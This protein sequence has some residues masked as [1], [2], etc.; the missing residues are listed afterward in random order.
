MV[1]EHD[2]SS[3][4]EALGNDR[5]ADFESDKPAYSNRQKSVSR[6]AS[7]ESDTA[8]DVAVLSR[9]DVGDDTDGSPRYKPSDEEV[10]FL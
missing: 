3:A 2:Y 1:S 5:E 9:K 10:M 4:I 7:S 8:S 6:S